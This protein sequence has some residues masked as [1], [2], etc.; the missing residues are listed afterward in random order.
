MPEWQQMFR[1]PEDIPERMSEKKGR[2][3]AKKNARIYAKKVASW[4]ARLT[5]RMSYYNNLEHY[6]F[7][8]KHEKEQ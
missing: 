8:M 1:V 4:N 6:C 7:L 5:T 2:Q 3:N